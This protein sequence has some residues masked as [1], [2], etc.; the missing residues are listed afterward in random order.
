M[1][2]EGMH[3]KSCEVL[4]KD[5]A[6]EQGVSIKKIEVKGNTGYIEA[7]GDLEQFKKEIESEGDYKVTL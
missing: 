4:I 7:E 2:V 5:I 1:K 3:C 6:E